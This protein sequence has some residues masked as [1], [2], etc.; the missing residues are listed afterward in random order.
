MIDKNQ[1][2]K[3]DLKEICNFL[4]ESGFSNLQSEKEGQKILESADLNNDK[5]LDFKL[6]H[7]GIHDFQTKNATH[8]K[9][10]KSFWPKWHVFIEF[11]RQYFRHVLIHFEE[12]RESVFSS[13]D[14][15]LEGEFGQEALSR[16]LGD[17][18]IRVNDILNESNLTEDGGISRKE[19]DLQMEE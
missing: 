6:C 1:D 3:L 17:D 19:F 5:V 11:A 4:V 8:F 13:L 9:W 16:I 2:G 7:F 14:P 10:V 12:Y 15:R 18:L